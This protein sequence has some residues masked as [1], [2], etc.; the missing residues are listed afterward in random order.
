MLGSTIAMCWSSAAVREYTHQH[1][2]NSRYG[3]V[4]RL[5]YRPTRHVGHRLIRAVWLAHR[6]YTRQTIAFPI[7]KHTQYNRYFLNYYHITLLAAHISR[8]L[9]SCAIVLYHF[10]CAGVTLNSVSWWLRLSAFSV[11]RQVNCNFCFLQSRHAGL[12]RYWGQIGPMYWR[13]Y[14]GLRH[15]NRPR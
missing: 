4:A 11:C 2:L 10:L 7:L 14:V 6:L 12:S 5:D 3:K 8:L 15:Y 1:G 9:W 13:C